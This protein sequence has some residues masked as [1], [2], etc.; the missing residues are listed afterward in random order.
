MACGGR[1]TQY[2]KRRFCGIGTYRASKQA[3]RMLAWAL[4]GRLTGSAVTVN[5]GN[6]GYVVTDLT[7]GVGGLLKVVVVLTS[8]RA[9][10]PLDR[11]DTAIWLAASPEVEAITGSPSGSPLS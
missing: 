5:A 6:P 11:A 4:A 8:F 3:S 1:G 7:G 2:Q 10:T 9:L